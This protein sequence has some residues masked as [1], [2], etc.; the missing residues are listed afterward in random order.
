MQSAQPHDTLSRSPT[1]ICRR[2]TLKARQVGTSRAMG[3]SKPDT[4]PRKEKKRTEELEDSEE[5]KRNTQGPLKDSPDSAAGSSCS[6]LILDDL[7]YNIVSRACIT[8]ADEGL[9]G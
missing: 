6:Q 2:R 5:A 3:L 7:L 8:A 9:K 4:V 1:L